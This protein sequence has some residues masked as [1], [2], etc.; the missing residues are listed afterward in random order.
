MKLVNARRNVVVENFRRKLHPYLTQMESSGVHTKCEIRSLL[1]LLITTPPWM[2]S[3]VLPHTQFQTGILQQ[4]DRLGHF[5]PPQSHHVFSA[6]GS[7]HMSL[8][9]P[10]RSLPVLFHATHPH[11]V[12][13]FS[14]YC[15]LRS[16]QNSPPLL[17]FSL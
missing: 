1:V 9:F 8:C 2:C 14:V 17:P 7:L 6:R 10:G 16:P 15:S 12:S 13:L 5:L 3:K 11:P 4:I